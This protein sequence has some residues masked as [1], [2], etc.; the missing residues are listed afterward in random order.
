MLSHVAATLERRALVAADDAV[1]VAVSGGADSVALAWILHELAPRASW[2]LAGL[3]HVN[4]GLRGAESDADEAFCRDLTVR[5]ALPIEVRHI[6]VAARARADRRSLESTA[7]DLRYAAFEDAADALGA[8]VVATGHTLDD[9]AETVLLR[10]L[11]GAGTRGL[12]G[13]RPRRGRY[14]RPL[15]DARRADLVAWLTARGEAWRTDASNADTSIPRNRIRQDLV[16]VVERVAP[17]GIAAL[18]RLADLAADDE[19]VFEARVVQILPA[20]AR[21]EA[22]GVQLNEAALADLPAA[23]CRRVLRAAMC[24]VAPGA[25]LGSAHLETVRRLVTSEGTG[26][27]IDL[28]GSSATRQAGWLRLAPAV[29][30]RPGAPLAF[31]RPLLVPGSVDVPEVGV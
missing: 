4:H 9:Q 1:A 5:M 26:R 24:Q 20:I 15:I 29:E 21:Y 25:R 3:I 18:A 10:A 17:G 14:R 12:S 8:T 27:R 16:P 7:R 22:G 2:R 31:E 11:T 19:A 13:V 28:P 30:R 6:D 23:L